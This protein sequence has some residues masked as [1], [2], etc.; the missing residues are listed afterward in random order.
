MGLINA[1]WDRRKGLGTYVASRSSAGAQGINRSWLE[2]RGCALE[3]PQQDMVGT[4][5]CAYGFDYYPPL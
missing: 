1:I 4:S 2:T 5:P 3:P